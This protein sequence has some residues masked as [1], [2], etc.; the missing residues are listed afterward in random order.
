MGNISYI[1]IGATCYRVVFLRV[2]QTGALEATA[3]PASVVHRPAESLLIAPSYHSTFR[4]LTV[5]YLVSSSL[6]EPSKVASA[7]FF[8]GWLLLR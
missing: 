5:V 6:E 4:G 3:V 7:F 8:P 2:T 1:L